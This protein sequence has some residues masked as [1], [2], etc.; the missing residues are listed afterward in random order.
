MND[1]EDRV[2]R[3]DL[4]V[5]TPGPVTFRVYDNTGI[6]KLDQ[7]AGAGLDLGRGC[8]ARRKPHLAALDHDEF[9]LQRNAR[10]VDEAAEELAAEPAPVAE[11]GFEIVG[12]EPQQQTFR[13]LELAL[14]ALALVSGL[15]ARLRRRRA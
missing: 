9:L 13:T 2:G 10:D 11:D 5:H 8:H 3:R 6:P 4:F 15:I 1:L 7:P 12:E 14:A